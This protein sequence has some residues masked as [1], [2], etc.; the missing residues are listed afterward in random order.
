VDFYL[1][2]V[3]HSQVHHEHHSLLGI[4]DVDPEHPE[5]Q[6]IA[7]QARYQDHTVHHSINVVLVRLQ[8]AQVL[9]ALVHI[10]PRGI[11]G[12]LSG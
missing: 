4:S 10:K 9:A 2:Q 5:R 1:Q 3:S 8:T 12:Q 11:H 6:H 7:Q